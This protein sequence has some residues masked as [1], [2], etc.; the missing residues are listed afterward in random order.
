LSRSFAGTTETAL[1]SQLLAVRNRRTNRRLPQERIS[2]RRIPGEVW[3]PGDYMEDLIEIRSRLIKGDLRALY[4]LWLC[5]AM[6][7]QEFDPHAPPQVR[8]STA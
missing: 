3:D 1:R 6:D 8:E 4:A 7:D 5:A 2:V